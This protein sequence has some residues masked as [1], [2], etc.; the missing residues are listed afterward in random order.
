MK[1]IFYVIKDIGE[2]NYLKSASLH[3]KIYTNSFINAMH[4]KNKRDAINFNNENEIYGKIFRADIE[5]YLYQ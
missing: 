4:F 2:I 3:E 5:P 1:E